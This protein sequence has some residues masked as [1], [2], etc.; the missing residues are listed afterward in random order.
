MYFCFKVDEL[1]NK[2]E[3]KNKLIEKK[4]QE[5]LQVY[6]LI[7][8]I[9]IYKKLN[10]SSEGDTR[11]EQ[12]FIRDEWVERSPGYQGQENKCST[13]KGILS[14]IWNFPSLFSSDWKLGGFVEGKGQSGWY[15]QVSSAT[16]NKI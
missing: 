10:V 8:E 2:L 14:L 4:T 16:G 1:R 9:C 7:H 3:Q 12:S 6:I 13:T 5:A 15:C 11:K